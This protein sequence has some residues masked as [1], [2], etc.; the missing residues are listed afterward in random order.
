MKNS[1]LLI[2]IGALVGSSG[3][4]GAVA[5]RADAAT[6][7]DAS[8]ATCRIVFYPGGGGSQGCSSYYAPGQFGA[9]YCSFPTATSCQTMGFA[10]CG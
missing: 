1:S 4:A 7:V 6:E 2:A 10:S 9:Q 3:L 8:C 5:T